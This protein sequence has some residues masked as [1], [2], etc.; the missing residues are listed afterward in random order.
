MFQTI[1]RFAVMAVYLLNTNF[2]RSNFQKDYQ[3]Q[4]KQNHG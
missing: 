3:Q 1:N 4:I 2:V